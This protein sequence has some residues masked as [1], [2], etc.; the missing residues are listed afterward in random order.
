MQFTKFAKTRKK[1]LTD[2]T[3]IFLFVLG[4]EYFIKPSTTTISMNSVSMKQCDLT[5]WHS[6][7]GPECYG[8]GIL[9]SNHQLTNR[10]WLH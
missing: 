1:N 6:N 3:Q 7:R 5:K 10:E 2:Q 9:G 8:F 4:V